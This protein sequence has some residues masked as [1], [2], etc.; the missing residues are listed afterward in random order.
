[1]D[2][3]KRI[4]IGAIFLALILC[5]TYFIRKALEDITVTYE[6]EELKDFYYEVN[7]HDLIIDSHERFG[8]VYKY[9]K[10]IFIS[11][12]NGCYRDLRDWIRIKE[13]NSKISVYRPEYSQTYVNPTYEQMVKLIKN[14]KLKPIISR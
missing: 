7:N 9:D 12:D 13:T 8:F 2:N 4:F 1:M 5:F 10:R 6:Y 11:E 3:R 14:Q